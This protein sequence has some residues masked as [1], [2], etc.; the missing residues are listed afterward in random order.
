MTSARQVAA[1][2]RNAQRSTGPRTA[3]GK[4]AAAG[5]AR[6]HG[7]TAAPPPGEVRRW[8][9]VILDRTELPSAEAFREDEGLARALALARAE[10]RVAALEA[11]LAE[12]S[13]GSDGDAGDAAG[14]EDPVEDSMVL[15]GYDVFEKRIDGRVV[16]TRVR[17]R[18]APE[19]DLARRYLREARGARKRAFR[20]WVAWLR[21]A[22][23][24]A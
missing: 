21:Q 17:E 12:L 8:L 5:N 23:S 11:R 7:L 24:P 10:A 9:G 14:G 18:V 15:V 22:G 1:N 13:D 3:A 4:A 16:E 2:R 20:A 19:R 6:R